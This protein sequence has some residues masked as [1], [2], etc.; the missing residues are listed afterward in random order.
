MTSNKR[1]IIIYVALISIASIIT[2]YKSGLDFGLDIR[3]IVLII[4][5][6]AGLT[7]K[8]HTSSPSINFILFLFAYLVYIALFV[9]GIK[10]KYKWA[11]HFILVCLLILNIRGCVI[12]VNEL[13]SALAPR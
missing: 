3:A 5:F 8:F 7:T 13:G 9:V 12:G 4:F 2:L 10:T 6:P 1:F 11:V